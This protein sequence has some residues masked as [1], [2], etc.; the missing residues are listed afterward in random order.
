MKIGA[1]F[2]SRM[3]TSYVLKQIAAPPP[4]AAYHPTTLLDGKVRPP[5]ISYRDQGRIRKACRMAGIDPASIGL[6]PEVVTYPAV[7]QPK[8]SEKEVKKYTRE[9][10]I[11]ENMAKMDERIAEWKEERRKLKES[12][13]P[14]L[15]F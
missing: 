11:V 7:K 10:N 14:E 3:P 2:P 13:K 4:A 5:R 12:T 1:K 15:P 6:P 9:K 8:G